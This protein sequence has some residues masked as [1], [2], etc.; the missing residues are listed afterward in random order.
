MASGGELG[1]GIP[2]GRPRVLDLGTG[3]GG[4]ATA[5]AAGLPGAEVHAVDLS[6]EA[7]EVAQPSALSAAS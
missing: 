2:G 1:G 5:L 3:S 7:L 6:A 4:P